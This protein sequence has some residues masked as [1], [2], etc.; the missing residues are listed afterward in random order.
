[1]TK[2]SRKRIRKILLGPNN[3]QKDGNER[4]RISRRSFLKKIGL[5]SLG[6]GAMGLS[7]TSGLRITNNGVLGGGDSSFNSVSS[8][9]VSKNV[10]LTTYLSSDQSITDYTVTKVN[11]DTASG[12][13]E[14]GSFNT[15]NN[16]IDI[17]ES[18]K[19][20]IS[21]QIQYESLS[22]SA[23]VSGRIVING[24]TST[25]NVEKTGSGSFATRPL[26]GKLFE[27]NQGDQITLETRHTS[28]SSETLRSG[29][30]RNYLSVQRLG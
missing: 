24:S 6:I 12:T 10:G 4:N 18:G 25:Y 21:G 5:G 9:E 11:I 15:S 26:A 23:T 19:Y 20:L 8:N 3:Q 7:A 2:F 14:R 28:S 30:H 22:S 13:D 17:K 1:M 29:A 16:S 27:L